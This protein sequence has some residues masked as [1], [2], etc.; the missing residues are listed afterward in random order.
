MTQIYDIKPKLNLLKERSKE[1]I[2]QLQIDI[3]ELQDVMK[4]PTGYFLAFFDK[5]GTPEVTYD[6]SIC[7]ANSEFVDKNGTTEDF[8]SKQLSEWG[9][10]V[11]TTMNEQEQEIFIAI[12]K[13][14]GEAIQKARDMEA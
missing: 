12:M 10:D 1:C 4:Y 6:M 14:V 13:K 3:K 11:I 8:I 2:E 5:H 7:E 9:Q